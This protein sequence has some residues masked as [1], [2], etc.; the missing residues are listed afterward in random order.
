MKDL[1]SK[2]VLV[3]LLGAAV[4]AADTDS[5]IVDLQGYNSAEIA[6]AIGAGG[7]A[8]TA[9]NKI[10]FVLTHSDDGVTFTPVTVNDVLGVAAVN[11]G[12]VKALVAAHAA[13][14]SYRLGYKGNRRYLKLTADFSGAHGTGTPIAAMLIKGAGFNRPEADQI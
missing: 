9:A 6:L 11:N 13:P 3:T 5:A 10:E 7:I 4:I 8:F 2:I 12:I 14:Q 1:H